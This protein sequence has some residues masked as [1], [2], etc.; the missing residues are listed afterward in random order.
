[1]QTAEV[2]LRPDQIRKVCPR[3]RRV[4]FAVLVASSRPVR[5]RIKIEKNEVTLTLSLQNKLDIADKDLSIK[6][7]DIT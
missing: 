5:V 3:L 2:F 4:L 7:V 6:E 1:M